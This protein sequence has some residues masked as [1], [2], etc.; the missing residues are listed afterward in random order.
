[1]LAALEQIAIGSVAV[2]ARAIAAAAADLTFLQWRA[3]VVVGAHPEGVTVGDLATGVGLQ[4]SPASRLV[5]RLAARGIVTSTP[6]ASDRRVRLVALS[7]K[8][9]TLR[10]AVLES[11]S[12]ELRRIAESSPAHDEAR[13]AVLRLGEAFAA[14]AS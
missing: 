14:V 7:A 13:A 10:A 9:R 5:S 8:G 4:Q 6:S 3:L 2:T 1:M 12:G 11:R